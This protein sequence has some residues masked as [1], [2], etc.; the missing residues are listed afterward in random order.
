MFTF[1]IHGQAD[2]LSLLEPLV[3]HL[4][5]VEIAIDYTNGPQPTPRVSHTPWCDAIEEADRAER[6]AKKRQINAAPAHV[7]SASVRLP[8]SARRRSARS[9]RSSAPQVIAAVACPTCK[10]QIDQ[11][12]RSTSGQDRLRAHRPY[13]LRAARGLQ[14]GGVMIRINDREVQLTD[15]ELACLDAHGMYLDQGHSTYEA[16]LLTRGLA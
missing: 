5:H 13:P 2:D 9:S 8:A 11:P 16:T 4:G 3:R 1:N 14:G 15:H 10:A 6:E 12:C 7:W